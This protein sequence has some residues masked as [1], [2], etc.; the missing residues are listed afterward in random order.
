MSVDAFCRWTVH[1]GEGFI[2]LGLTRAGEGYVT[3]AFFSEIS[4]AKSC[5]PH[6]PHDLSEQPWI[7][8]RGSHE[9]HVDPISNWP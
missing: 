2:E 7:A 8:R 4:D 3:P 6:C 9:L 1:D 5:L